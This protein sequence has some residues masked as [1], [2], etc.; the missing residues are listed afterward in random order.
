MT[1]EE[2]NKRIKA[3]EEY[4]ESDQYKNLFSSEASANII[5]N[6]LMLKRPGFSYKKAYKM[7]LKL[8]KKRDKVDKYKSTLVF[9]S[10]DPADYYKIHIKAFYIEFENNNIEFVV[11]HNDKFISNVKYKK[12]GANNNEIY[13][14]SFDAVL[15]NVKYGDKICIYIRKGSKL[16]K[17]RITESIKD[18]HKN[19]GLRITKNKK[20]I[21]RSV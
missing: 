3:I 6:A 14:H 9:S 7:L 21:I 8:Q 2:Y 10:I 11:Q 17:L 18:Y 13:E 19:L 4:L 20:C 15:E 5:Y 12:T 1:E 16:I